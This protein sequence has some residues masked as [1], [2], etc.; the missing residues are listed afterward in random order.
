MTFAFLESGSVRRAV[1][2]PQHVLGTIPMQPI[3][4]VRA[5]TTAMWKV[6]VLLA[7]ENVALNRSRCR[8]MV[9]L[10]RMG[11]RVDGHWTPHVTLAREYRAA[12]CRRTGSPP[13]HWTGAPLRAGAVD[14]VAQTAA[15]AARCCA[16]IP[17]KPT[18]IQQTIATIYS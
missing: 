5:R 18:A 13:V 9:P 17:L 6:A 14:T 16:A 4:I 2:E 8:L 3:L 12:P 7:D 15:C 11:L 10:S 1:D